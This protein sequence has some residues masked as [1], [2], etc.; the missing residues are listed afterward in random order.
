MSQTDGDCADVMTLDDVVKI[1]PKCWL[2]KVHEAHVNA[3]FAVL[4][5]KQWMR[6]ASEASLLLHCYYTF[7]CG[8]T[9]KN[10]K[11]GL[12]PKYGD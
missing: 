4:I 6:D 10:K 11:T 7:F 9:F 5:M 12:I 1:I 3:I 8:Y 2:A